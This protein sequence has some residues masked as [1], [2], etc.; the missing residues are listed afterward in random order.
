MRSPGES[1]PLRRLFAL[2]HE[3]PAHLGEGRLVALSP[4][5]ATMPRQ[6]GRRC[7]LSSADL[8]ETPDELAWLSPH[9]MEIHWAD[10]HQSRYLLDFLR[11]NCPCAE[12]QGHGLQLFQA[13]PEKLAREPKQSVP[14]VEVQQVGTYA[15]GIT[16]SDGHKTGIF[17][18][19]FL[20]R[21][22]PCDEC[23]A[24]ARS[25][26]VGDDRK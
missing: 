8:K 2:G 1:A 25:E 13:L 19:R 23:R 16:F 12:C 15:I 18:Y 4:N 10:G 20:R 6:H 26:T 21:F 9:E 5:V 7:V 14:P 24:A 11:L 22:C 17:S 3:E